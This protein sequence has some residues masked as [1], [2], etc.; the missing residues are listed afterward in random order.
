MDLFYSI[1]T[2]KTVLWSLKTVNQEKP[3]AVPP[4]TMYYVVFYNLQS[5]FFDEYN[6]SKFTKACSNLQRKEIL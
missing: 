3:Q 2:T 1:K 4:F 6:L 5:Q